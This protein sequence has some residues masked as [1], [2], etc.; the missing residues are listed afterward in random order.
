MLSN[1]KSSKTTCFSSEF[2]FFL[3]KSIKIDLHIHIIIE[4]SQEKQETPLH[5]ACEK[6][7]LPIV[8]YLIEKSANIE[9]KDN[10]QETPLHRAS[11]NDNTDIVEYLV[12]KDANKNT[13]DIND[14]T[15]S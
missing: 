11:V 15:T 7:N 3:T 4:S 5:F 8:Q 1:N 12:S 13:K 10:Y 14:K 9:A 2:C 6:D